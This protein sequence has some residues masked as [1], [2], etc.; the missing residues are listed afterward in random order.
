MGDT[1]NRP[2]F[3]GSVHPFEDDNDATGGSAWGFFS[4]GDDATESAREAIQSRLRRLN[5]RLVPVFAEA[6]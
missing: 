3:S 5:R 6:F 2:A 1:S 4:G